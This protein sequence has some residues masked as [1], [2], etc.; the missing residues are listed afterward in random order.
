MSK[1]FRTNFILSKRLY[2]LL[3]IRMTNTKFIFKMSN[4]KTTYTKSNF[5]HHLL[6]C[7]KL[8]FYTQISTNQLFF[9][10]DSSL[11]IQVVYYY[12][13]SFSG[14]CDFNAVSELRSL[15]S[16]LEELESDL[17]DR[18]EEIST[19]KDQKPTQNGDESDI[20]KVSIY[21][22]V[23]NKYNSQLALKIFGEKKVLFGEVI[24]F[25]S[26]VKIYKSTFCSKFL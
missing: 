15:K 3:L 21:Y 20:V 11:S 5:F 16:R 4:K 26:G 19:L 12:F 8:A 18:D 1:P 6:S 17:K 24:L 9:S 13:L 25:V 10:K 22:I 23:L 14:N 2:S 7:Q